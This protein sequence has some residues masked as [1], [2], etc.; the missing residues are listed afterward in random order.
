MQEITVEDLKARRDAG[1]E[2]F[3]LDVRDQDEYDLGNIGGYLIP[4]DELPARMGELDKGREIVVHCRRGGRAAKAI[5]AL[6][7]SGFKN[8]KNLK[9]GITAWSERIDPS[10]KVE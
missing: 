10:V 4:L 5:E 1:D 9:G 3:V 8:V 2:V 7:A 6:E